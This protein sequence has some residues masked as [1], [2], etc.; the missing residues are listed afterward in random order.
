MIFAAGSDGS[1]GILKD[2]LA[3]ESD[4]ITLPERAWQKLVGWYGMVKGQVRIL[5]ICIRDFGH[6]VWQK[7]NQM[8]LM[9][10]TLVTHHEI[11]IFSVQSLIENSQ[12][13]NVKD[14]VVTK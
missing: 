2:Y 12:H 6:L 1:C 7:K 5:W 3:E 4:Y 8:Y 14:L 13:H 10:S 9:A 11:H